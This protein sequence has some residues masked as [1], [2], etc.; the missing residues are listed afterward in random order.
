MILI[1]ITSLHRVQHT[2]I[3]KTLDGRIS[4]EFPWKQ[5]RTRF[6]DTDHLIYN[7]SKHGV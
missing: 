5:E 6:F 7:S 1:G 3:K 2:G 4:L